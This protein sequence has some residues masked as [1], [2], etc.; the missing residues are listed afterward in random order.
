MGFLQALDMAGAVE[1]EDV[2]LRQAIA[3]HLAVNHYPPVSDTMISPCLAAIV[4]WDEGDP[5]RQI[6]L[7]GEVTYRDSK[8]A[9]AW[10]V[11]RAH[12]LEAFLTREEE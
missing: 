9:P 5:E 6:I 11:I 3:W 10:A 1:R 8:F 4:A 12:H 7:P 2:S